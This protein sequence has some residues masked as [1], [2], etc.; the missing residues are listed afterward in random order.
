MLI[1]G[2][3]CNTASWTAGSTLLALGLSVS[4][5]MGIIIGSSLIIAILAVVSGVSN[6]L[7]SYD[8]FGSSGTIYCLLPEQY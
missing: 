5:A 6:P 1:S 8:F 7:K 3:G 2:T 4:Q